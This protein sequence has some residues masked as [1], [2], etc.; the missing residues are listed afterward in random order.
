VVAEG[1]ETAE[2]LDTVRGLGI[3]E[4]QGY[5]LAR[6]MPAADMEAF[7]ETAGMA[8]SSQAESA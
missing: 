5:L 8:R 2:Q 3:E 1:I 6:P 4:G 7:L